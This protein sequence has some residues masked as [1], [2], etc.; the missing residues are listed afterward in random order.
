MRCL[1]FCCCAFF[2][3]LAC[4]FAL[5]EFSEGRSPSGWDNAYAYV[6][7]SAI[8]FFSF[9]DYGKQPSDQEAK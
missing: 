7:S 2:F 4:A 9:R 3:L 1:I 6:L 5:V 8:L